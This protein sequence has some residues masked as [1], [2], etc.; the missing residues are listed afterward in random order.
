MQDQPVSF[1]P[2]RQD[3]L[4]HRLTGIGPEGQ[5]SAERLAKHDPGFSL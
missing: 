3:N 1:H 4:S 2:I 5:E